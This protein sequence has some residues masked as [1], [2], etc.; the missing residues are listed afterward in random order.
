MDCRVS[1][2]GF[3]AAA[4][5]AAIILAGCAGMPDQAQDTAYTYG[6][7]VV[8]IDTASKEIGAYNS[9]IHKKPLVNEPIEQTEGLGKLGN[10][11][12][13]DRRLL[14]RGSPNTMDD[15]QRGC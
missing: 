11:Q 6:C 13:R 1:I 7:K 8:V 10:I 9:D 12:N 15:A 5:G 3:C 2:I 14:G 4:T